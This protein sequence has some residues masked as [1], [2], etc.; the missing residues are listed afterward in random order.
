MKIIEGAVEQAG[1]KG[2]DQLQRQGQLAGE[3][4]LAADQPNGEYACRYRHTLDIEQVDR[5]AEDIVAGQEQIVS[6]TL[7]VPLYSAGLH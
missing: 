2:I 6:G 3:A 7:L 1:I 4:Q 5:R